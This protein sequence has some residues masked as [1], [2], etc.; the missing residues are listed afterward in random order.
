MALHLTK[1]LN[2]IFCHKKISKNL[3][4]HNKLKKMYGSY[5]R[6]IHKTQDSECCNR[7]IKVLAVQ[8]IG[9]FEK[10]EVNVL[11]LWILMIGIPQMMFWN[12][13]IIW[14]KYLGKIF[15]GDHYCI[16]MEK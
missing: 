4:F 13:C 11:H 9:G 3:K 10:Q 12:H 16:G 1:C 2:R 6:R 15:P 14:Q 7:K 5:Y 8:E